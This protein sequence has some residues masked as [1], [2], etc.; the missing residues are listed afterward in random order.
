MR[1]RKNFQSLEAA[2]A[3]RHRLTLGG[4][5]DGE[6]ALDAK[7]TRL[8]ARE[9]GDAEA[10]RN[11][12][13]VAGFPGLSLSQ[14]VSAYLS[15]HAAKDVNAFQAIDEFV[16]A[17][18]LRGLRQKTA[19]IRR[20]I[21]R[22]FVFDCCGDVEKVGDISAEHLDNW[23]YSA[24]ASQTQQSRRSIL[25]GFFSWLIRN[26]YAAENLVKRV[27]APKVEREAP[28]IL[29]AEE[30]RKLLN[31]AA[32]VNAGVMLPYFG[33]ALLSGARPEEA[34]RLND[35]RFFDLDDHN[36]IRIDETIAK[37]CARFIPIC[38]KLK[39]I[40]IDCRKRGIVPGFFNRRV[41]R[42]VRKVAGLTSPWTGAQNDIM[43]HSFASF[44]YALDQDLA[45]L[46]QACG[47]SPNILRSRYIQPVTRR[48]AE[49]FFAAL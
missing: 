19:D 37:T 35:W 12:L 27:E 7:L 17:K 44:S 32:T 10:A 2:N 47:N 36:I 1:V 11:A 28:A 39:S 49:A 34:M 9:I 40:L 31:A 3:E 43:R 24:K 8:S 29:T 25:H 21:L 46:S 26:G 13:D 38:P 45:K 18:Q 6:R 15:R 14:A 42:R 33:V 16:K 23:V 48:E 20:G 5:K 30:A 4:T 41:F 22:K